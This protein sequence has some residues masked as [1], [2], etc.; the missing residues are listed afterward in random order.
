MD[1]W[2]AHAPRSTYYHRH[3]PRHII[4]G[5]GN[6]GGTYLHRELGVAL[7][8]LSWGEKNRAVRG[9]FLEHALSWFQT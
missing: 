4:Y 8:K 9:M 7:P 1:I 6:K 5:L 2:N 3:G